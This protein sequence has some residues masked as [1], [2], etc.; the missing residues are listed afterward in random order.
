[1]KVLITGVGG[2]IGANFVEYLLKETDWDIFSIDSF[3][4]KGTY[5]RLD[6]CIP[7]FAEHRIRIFNHDLTVPIDRSL[8]NLLLE[9]SIDKDGL[10]QEKPFDVVF[11]LASDSAVER[12]IT[13]PGLCWENNTKLI[14]NMLEFVRH[15]PVKKFIHISTDE[16]YD[17]CNAGREWSGM[18]PGNIYSA[19]KAAQEM[20]CC[21]YYKTYDLPIVITNCVNVIGESQD[22]EKFIPRIIQSIIKNE[23]IPIYATNIDNKL[24]VGNR[25][26]I[27][28]RDK[29]SALKLIAE[30][31]TSRYSEGKEHLDKYHISSDYVVDNL[32]VAQMVAKIVG[33]ELRYKIITTEKVRP[34]YDH[35]YKLNDDKLRKLGWKQ[36]HTLEQ[37]LERV[38][39]ETL[40]NMKWI[41]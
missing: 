15:N 22:P 4:H 3:E 13:A 5:S 38:V 31:P 20:L 26:Y 34:G 10:V 32:K 40:D 41:L 8:E 36:T 33:K 16:V 21:A 6:N 14:L 19:S 1:M 23:E 25:L 24:V 12:S 37:T 17:H 27:D 11:N 30:L 9:R 35:C 2:F 7:V 28:V 39:R 18:N 29:A